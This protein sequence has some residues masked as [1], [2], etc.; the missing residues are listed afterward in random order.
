MARRPDRVGAR[1]GGNEES[2]A[3]APESRV[4]HADTAFAI[5]GAEARLLLDEREL[6]PLAATVAPDRAI[7]ASSRVGR[8]DARAGGI[9]DP[10]WRGWIT[11]SGAPARRRRRSWAGPR[12]A[13][14]GARP[15]R[16]VAHSVASS[17]ASGFTGLAV[18]RRACSHNSCQIPREDSSRSSLGSTWA[19]VPSG[20]K[21]RAHVASETRAPRHRGAVVARTGPRR[22]ARGRRTSPRE[23]LRRPRRRPACPLPQVEP[24]VARS[25]GARD[26]GIEEPHAGCV[27]RAFLRARATPSSISGGPRRAARCG[28]ASNAVAHVAPASLRRRDLAGFAAAVAF[29]AKRGAVRH[30][31]A[32][33]PG[34][35]SRARVPVDFALPARV[36]LAIRD[37]EAQPLRAWRAASPTA[38]GPGPVPAS[39]APAAPSSISGGTA[40][41]G[42]PRSRVSRRCSFA[43][44]SVAPTRTIPSLSS[45]VSRGRACRRDRGAARGRVRSR[46]LRARAAP[47][48]I[49]GRITTGDSPRSPVSCCFAAPECLRCPRRAHSQ[50]RATRPEHGQGFR[51]RSPRWRHRDG[52]EG[53][54]PINAQ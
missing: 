9:E 4:R 8:V 37:A 10:R 40:T 49:S 20:S 52:S 26:V 34:S 54:S 47:S 25:R 16:A 6:R 1:A 48:L 42:S 23:R 15:H 12:R 35:R 32:R 51:M 45:Q 46:I 19:R 41:R 53:L 27:D 50:D 43:P 2:R 29:S 18:G 5:R 21:R 24:F 22:A 13:A 11:H 33:P 14:S 7:R 31:G 36:T 28:R 44:R 30:V 3:G 17:R 38:P 39:S